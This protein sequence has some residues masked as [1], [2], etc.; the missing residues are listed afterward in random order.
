MIECDDVLIIIILHDLLIYACWI[1]R[2]RSK[3]KDFFASPK[4]CSSPGWVQRISYKTTFH[5]STFTLAN[6]LFI[7]TRKRM[8][9]YLCWVWTSRHPICS[10]VT[11][12]NPFLETFY[13]T[14][15]KCKLRKYKDSPVWIIQGGYGGQRLRFV[16]F[17]LVHLLCHFCPLCSCPSMQNWADSGTSKLKSTKPSRCPAWSPCTCKLLDSLKGK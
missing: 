5:V 14:P 15:C 1:T 8:L 10:Y 7:S 16:D 6:L 2:G 17:N 4:M 13:E 11:G 12:L 3:S 9:L